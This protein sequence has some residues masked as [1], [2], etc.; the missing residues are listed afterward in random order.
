MAKSDVEL[1]QQLSQ[2]A[3]NFDHFQ[4][5]LNQSNSVFTKFREDTDRLKKRIGELE[6]EIS[7]LRVKKEKCEKSISGLKTD[8]AR[9]EQSLNQTNGQLEKLLV[10]ILK[11]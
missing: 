10:K 6:Q 5:A 3:E 2:Y 8:E 4:G 11:V 9:Y 1:K 7:G